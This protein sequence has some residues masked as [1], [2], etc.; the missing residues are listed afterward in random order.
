AL[1]G[2][3]PQPVG[4]DVLLVEAPVVLL[5]VRP[6][7]LRLPRQS[8]PV[9]ALVE[10]GSC[11]DAGV[12]DGEP[13]LAAVAGDVVGGRGEPRGP[14]AGRDDPQVGLGVG[15]Q[16]GQRLGEGRPDGGRVDGGVRDDAGGGVTDPGNGG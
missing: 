1:P 16:A 11:L 6:V 15:G 9:G 4:V 8:Q 7:G 3:D 5:V 13:L 12:A 2:E 14:D 10:S